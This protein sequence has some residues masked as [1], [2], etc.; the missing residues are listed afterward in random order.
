MLTR[1][2]YSD[3]FVDE[4]VI[5]K[6]NDKGNVTFDGAFPLSQ[7]PD[8]NLRVSRKLGITKVYLILR[9]DFD[10]SDLQYAFTYEGTSLSEDKY[11]LSNVFYD[12]SEERGYGLFYYS[13]KFERGSSDPLYTNSINNVDFNI[14]E[15]SPGKP[16]RLLVH[17]DD[18]VTPAWAS[19]S[20][21]YQIFVDRFNRGSVKVDCRKDAVI[22]PDWENGIPEFAEV[23]GDDLANNTFFGGTLYGVTEK[24]DYL[25]ELG[26]TCIYLN[27]IFKAFSNHK[28]DTG[29]YE[30]VD[31]MFGGNEAFDLLISEAKR[32]N[33]RVILDGVFNHTGDDSKYFNKYDRYPSVGAYQSEDSPYH[34][35]Y[36]F[37]HFPDDY[38]S[39]WGIKV[40]PKLNNRIPETRDYFL[41]EKGIVKSWLKRGASG[42]RLDVA[43]ELPQEFLDDLRKSVKSTDIDALIIGEVW[44]NAAEKIAYGERRRYF[45]GSQVDSVMN[46]PIKNAIIDFVKSGNSHDFYNEVTDIYSGYPVQCSAVLMNILGTHDTERIL[47]VLGG[48]SSQGKTN[49]QLSAMHL[50]PDEKK[51]GVRLL[52]CASVLQFTLPGIPNIFYGDEAGLEGYHD[53][54]CRRPFPWGREDEELEN[55]YKK[56]CAIKTRQEELHTGI[57]RFLRHDGGLIV[58]K[59]VKGTPKLIVAVNCSNE[60]KNFQVEGSF[61]DLI[62]GNNYNGIVNIGAQTPLILIKIK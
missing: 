24:L 16:F 62:S 57:I 50:S 33:I 14:A 17:T 12:L 48:E 59:R 36:F 47:T 30:T 8:L 21:M 9:S 35:W 38:Q 10:N 5:E 3:N 29:D 41:G 28:Y 20:V 34:N 55:H 26:I 11:S 39:W 58:F 32:R 15:A 13:I 46:Y 49:R 43:D 31:E 18:F 42:W 61:N 56:L 45:L 37:N 51:P 19:S 53:P 1:Y 6:F 40:L 2:P 54:F 44:E 4:I 25:Q 52:K 7:C 60:P 23:N 22:N 27:P